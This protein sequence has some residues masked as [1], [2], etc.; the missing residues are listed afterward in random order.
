MNKRQIS[1]LL[2]TP[3]VLFLISVFVI[4]MV[5]GVVSFWRVFNA[6]ARSGWPLLGILALM[7]VLSCLGTSGRKIALR[8][9]SVSL[10][11]YGVAMLILVAL[12]F[13]ELV[14]PHL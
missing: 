5:C 14:S 12:C 11:G 4:G 13:H 7:A 8:I 6:I 10:W 9:V 2:L 1:N 3:L